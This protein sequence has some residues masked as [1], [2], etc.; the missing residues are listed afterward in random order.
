MFANNLSSIDLCPVEKTKDHQLLTSQNSTPY[1]F[2]TY[3]R[4][5]YDR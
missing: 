4:I 5:R 3:D 2:F 1:S